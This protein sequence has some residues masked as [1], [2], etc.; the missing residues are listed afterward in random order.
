MKP[1][2]YIGLALFTIVAVKISLV[3]LSGTPAIYRVLALAVIGLCM[4]A[5]SYAYL[6]YGR[7]KEGETPAKENEQ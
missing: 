1:L 4:L 6:R 5:G 2:R 7:Q 3:D